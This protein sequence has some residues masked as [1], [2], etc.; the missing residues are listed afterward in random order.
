MVVD[1][2]GERDGTNNVAGGGWNPK[3]RFEWPVSDNAGIWMLKFVELFLVL[4]ELSIADIQA[5]QQSPIHSQ[6]SDN[7]VDVARL[8]GAEWGITPNDSA[9]YRLII[10]HDFQ[11]FSIPSFKS[12]W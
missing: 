3:V 4:R 11:L 5:I 7:I 12:P 10:P 2:A 9:F 8:R 1:T 6:L